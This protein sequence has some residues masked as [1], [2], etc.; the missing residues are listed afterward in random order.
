MF[1]TS[2]PEIT[3]LP[4]NNSKSNIIFNIKNNS[5]SAI[6]EISKSTVFF[7]T[8]IWNNSFLNK[9]LSVAKLHLKFLAWKLNADSGRNFSFSLVDVINTTSRFLRII[10]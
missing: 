3:F 8:P 5:H 6:V 1:W 9:K 10:L 2:W 4:G 7:Y